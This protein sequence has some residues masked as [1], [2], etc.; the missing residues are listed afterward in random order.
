[1]VYAHAF[2]F[3]T[4][5]RKWTIEKT[6]LQHQ[7]N[8]TVLYISLKMK[9]KGGRITFIKF[10]NILP[11]KIKRNKRNPMN[12]KNDLTWLDL[13]CI[14]A[15]YTKGWKKKRS[16]PSPVSPI[17]KEKGGLTATL[18]TFITP[19]WLIQLTS[20]QYSGSSRSSYIIIRRDR[21]TP[22]KACLYREKKFPVLPDAENLWRISYAFFLK[23]E[24]Y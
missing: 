8:E 7:N 3:F 22:D 2:F 11:V 9:K 19:E 1:M 21:V 6:S 18:F 5:L 17:L 15:V 14:V 4:P 10:L 13:L 12:E 16:A 20:D 24:N 23:Q